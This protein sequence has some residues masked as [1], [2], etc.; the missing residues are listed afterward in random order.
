M[1]NL[2]EWISNLVSFVGSS[3]VVLFAA[4]WISPYVS[5]LLAAALM[6]HADSTDA[7]RKERRFKWESYHSL[8]VNRK[9]MDEDEDRVK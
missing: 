3:A 2:I 9:E 5:R 7:R 4:A 1:V 6:A 8:F